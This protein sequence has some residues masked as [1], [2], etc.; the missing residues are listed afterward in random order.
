MIR[1]ENL[2]SSIGERVIFEKLNL[3][4][5]S[6][7]LYNLYSNEPCGKTALFNILAGI[8]NK[9]KGKI[10]GLTTRKLLGFENPSDSFLLSCFQ[11]EVYSVCPD[12]KTDRIENELIKAGIS[13]SEPSRLK[14]QNMSFQEQN[15]LV[16]ILGLF[17]EFP[18]Y[19]FDCT[20]DVLL[21]EYRDHLL[22]RYSEKVEKEES[23]FICFSR[24]P[25]E[26]EDVIS[27][28]L[29]LI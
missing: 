8:N 18:L 5:K 9:F 27:L 20:F 13:L 16:I 14:I 28:Q 11:D 6:G 25:F 22:S 12:A 15:K 24:F 26:Y 29:E 23:C 17:G 1:I 21:K 10:S 4:F 2:S 7:V 19:L 3:E